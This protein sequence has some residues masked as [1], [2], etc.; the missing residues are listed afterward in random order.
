MIIKVPD[1]FNQSQ[2]E[3]VATEAINLIKNRT[4]TGLDVRG[5]AFKPYSPSYV[6]DIDFK[7]AGKKKNEVNLQFTGEMI[8]EIE[9]LNQGTGFIV[10]GY[11]EG[12]SNKRVSY[13]KDKGREFLGITEKER[14]K[15]LRD[16]SG[17]TTEEVDDVIEI[18]SLTE[19]ILSRLR[20]NQ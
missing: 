6:K 13:N 19:R 17:S 3:A 12:E 11:Q 1:N 9:V 5:R 7:I 4:D 8:N 14:L 2:R 20:G 15:I 10:I 18:P 16:I